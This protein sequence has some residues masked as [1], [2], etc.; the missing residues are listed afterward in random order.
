MK[1]TKHLVIK[2]FLPYDKTSMERYL[3]RQALRG[4]MLDNT[5]K[6]WHFYRTEPQNLQF[7]VYY[8]PEARPYYPKL[9]LRQKEFLELSTHTGW[10]LVKHLPGMLV[11]CNK[12]PEPIPVET[13]PVLEVENIRKATVSRYNRVWW[14][15]LGLAVWWCL[16][17]WREFRDAVGLH[18]VDSWNAPGVQQLEIWASWEIFLVPLLAVLA[19]AT[20][21][22]EVLRFRLWH[23]KARRLAEKEDRFYAPR[24]SMNGFPWLWMGI[25]VAGV[26][27]LYL[28]DAAYFPLF[29]LL[30]VCLAATLVCVVVQFLKENH[31]STKRRALTAVAMGLVLSVSLVLLAFSP[32]VPGSVNTPERHKVLCQC[33]GEAEPHTIWQE[34]IP[35]RTEDLAGEPRAVEGVETYWR[36]NESPFFGRYFAFQTYCESQN[37]AR[38]TN[39]VI[40]D[41]KIPGSYEVLKE[42]IMYLGDRDPSAG[43]YYTRKATESDEWQEIWDDPAG[44]LQIFQLCNDEGSQMYYILCMETRIVDLKPSWHLS[45]AQLLKAAEILRDCPLPNT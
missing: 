11:L 18:F 43:T 32:A 1:T 6:G 8:F 37:V 40:T 16:S 17:A 45:Q 7:S 14:L 34:D 33:Q 30:G 15:L 29:L 38:T 39:Y 20:W 4:W 23:R 41:I 9:T 36:G 44:K 5:R 35:L 3:R 21:S 31:V 26:L 2:P 27:T 28:W 13:D 24:H 12:D 19:F 10:Y 25:G 42:E 22:A